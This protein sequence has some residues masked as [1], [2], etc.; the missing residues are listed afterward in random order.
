MGRVLTLLSACLA[1]GSVQGAEPECSLQ[2]CIWQTDNYEFGDAWYFAIPYSH[3]YDA[4]YM[5]S[6]GRYSLLQPTFCNAGNW[7][8]YDNCLMKCPFALVPTSPD[9][10]SMRACLADNQFTPFAPDAHIDLSHPLNEKELDFVAMGGPGSSTREACEPPNDGKNYSGKIVLVNR[11]TCSFS[12]KARVVAELGGAACIVVNSRSSNSIGASTVYSDRMSGRSSGFEHLPAAMLPKVLGDIILATMDA[13]VPVRG[14]LSLDCAVMSDPP[15]PPP[16]SG[17]STECPHGSLIGVC[18]DMPR[19]EQQLCA[20][21]AVQMAIVGTNDTACLYGHRL[22]PRV[23]GNSLLPAGSG[24]VEGVVHLAS[25]IPGFTLDPNCEDNADYTEPLTGYTCKDISDLI[26][27]GS[28]GGPDTLQNCRQIEVVLGAPAESQAGF[29]ENCLVTCE[30]CP[31]GTGTGCAAA[32]FENAAGRI[33]ALPAPSLCPAYT[34]VREAASMGVRAVVLLTEG[35][36]P[37]LVEGLSTFVP[38]PVDALDGPGSTAL[39]QHI[40]A[41]RRADPTLTGV[42]VRIG[43]SPP[44]QSTPA[45][46]ATAEGEQS[47]F[48]LVASEGFSLTPTAAVALTFAVLFAIAIVCLIARQRLSAVGAR[49]GG[50][51]ERRGVKVPLSAA[52]TILSLSLL[53]TVAAVAFSLAYVAGRDTTDA[54]M[55]DGWSAVQTTHSNAVVTVSRLKDQLLANIVARASQAIVAELT[56][57]ASYARIGARDFF[58]WDGTWDD[59]D[60]RVWQIT[61]FAGLTDVRW[62]TVIRTGNG[63]FASSY[64]KTDDRRNVTRADGHPH[65]SVSND[66][67][68]YGINQQIYKPGGSVASIDEW[69]PRDTWDPSKSLGRTW[70]D[71]NAVMKKEKK[72][73]VICMTPR[74]TSPIPFFVHAEYWTRALSCLAPIYNLS[75]TFVGTAQAHIRLGWKGAAFGSQLAKAAGSKETANMTIIVFNELGEFVTASRG[76]SSRIIEAYGQAITEVVARVGDS[77]TVPIVLEYSQEPY[78]NAAASYMK[79]AM[80]LGRLGEAR[81]DFEALKA[82]PGGGEFDQREWYGR[83]LSTRYVALLM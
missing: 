65:V 71:V 17:E 14:R 76:R 55:E 36:A 27:A 33:V 47:A 62:K 52:S 41:V 42:A 75:D 24:G 39:A 59:F 63:F 18:D 67:H 66:G 78:L 81:F 72:G 7:R 16:P 53:F 22:L 57:G 5:K 45:P 10:I 80:G 28:G 2:Q 3:I 83:G 74:Q 77:M 49:N 35:E 37:F 11:G 44:T 64:L 12:T 13:G 4:R 31:G 48:V 34:M 9:N 19:K 73:S 1:A 26:D 61:E 51:E 23:A 25:L 69:I 40:A 6:D 58:T 30:R 54:A 50:G 70:L 60:K 82:S 8:A 46:A 56:A 68:L 79:G 29:L 15:P 21:C 20:R 43:T 32:D 38:I